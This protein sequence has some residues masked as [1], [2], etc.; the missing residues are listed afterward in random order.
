MDNV[1][2]GG[3]FVEYL[4]DMDGDDADADA[5]LEY[6][7]TRIK[8]GFVF[9]VLVVVVVVGRGRKPGVGRDVHRDV[10]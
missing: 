5:P 10:M 8:S 7:G 1:Y 9:S 6:V 4:L 3:C 2:L